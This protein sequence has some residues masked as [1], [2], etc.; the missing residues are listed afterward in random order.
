MLS[1]DIF[2]QNKNK[3]DVCINNVNKCAEQLGIESRAKLNSIY[4]NV[5]YSTYDY[6]RNAL[7]ESRRA[8]MLFLF[9]N[10]LKDVQE[11]YPYYFQSIEG[12]G[13]LLKVNPTDGIRLKDGENILTI[14]F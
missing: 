13:N 1:D 12:I 7:G 9:V 10:S 5:D 14:K 3:V 11:H 6:L 4:N 8:D 2:S